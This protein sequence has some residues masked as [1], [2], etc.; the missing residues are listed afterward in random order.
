MR[1]LLTGT[2]TRVGKTMLGC[3]LAFAFKV[4]G[5]R[6]GVMKPV[7]TG[8]AEAN[9]ALVPSDGP[10]LIASASSDLPIALVSPYRYRST[11]PPA[12]AAEAD[13]ASPPNFNELCRIH[14]DIAARSDV[15]IVEDCGGLAAPIDWNNDYADLALAL[16]LELIFVVANH[17]RRS[18]TEPSMGG[19]RVGESRPESRVRELRSGSDFISAARLATEYAMR[20][21]LRISGFILNALDR[22][23]STSVQRDADFVARATRVFCLGTVRFKEPIS[24]AIVEQLL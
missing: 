13:N 10:A 6:V 16:G 3:A 8:C 15:T 20:R 1:L 22:E 17:T 21:G 14:R 19:G 4:R 18:E 5:M 9:G 23:S 24:L 2:D 12:A 7:E 11:L